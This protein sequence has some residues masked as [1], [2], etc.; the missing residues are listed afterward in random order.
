MAFGHLVFM[1]SGHQAN[2]GAVSSA[3]G[4]SGIT[5]P[6]SLCTLGL[7]ISVLHA[8]GALC[9]VTLAPCSLG[10]LP[11]FVHS[12]NRA[13]WTAVFRVL[14]V[15]G[16]K[17]PGLCALRFLHCGHWAPR[18][19]VLWALCTHGCYAHWIF[20]TQSSRT[21]GIGQRGHCVPWD[22]GTLCIG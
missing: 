6:W 20:C 11:E 9:P 4:T 16:I 15:L 21:L 17:H 8:L 12:G 10:L 19:Q 22:L 1:H 3:L 18:G 14:C 13:H 5:C 7:C 2:R